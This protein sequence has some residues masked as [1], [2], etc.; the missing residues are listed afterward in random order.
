MVTKRN[1]LGRAMSDINCMMCLANLAN[2]A[3]DGKGMSLKMSDGIIHAAVPRPAWGSVPTLVCVLIK[4]SNG[5][6][7][8]SWMELRWGR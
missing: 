6:W 3:P 5:M 8:P 1:G 4:A 2:G 7:I